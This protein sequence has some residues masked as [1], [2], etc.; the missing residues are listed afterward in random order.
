MARAK[1]VYHREAIRSAGQ[2]IGTFKI[3]PNA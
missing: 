2:Q 1:R 3:S